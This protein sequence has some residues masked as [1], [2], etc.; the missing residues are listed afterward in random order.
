MTKQ[1]MD[2]AARKIH[3]QCAIVECKNLMGKVMYYGVAW[4]N[5]KM[6]EL[7]SERDDCLLEMPWGIYDGRKGVER[8]Y[9]QDFG[10]RNDP[11]KLEKLKGVMMLYT[12]DTPIIEVAEDGQSAKGVWISSG[13]DTW[14]EGDAHPQGYWRWGK[15]AVEFLLEQGKWKIWRM[16]FYPFFLTK[17]DESWTKAPAYDWSFFPVTPDRPR[18]T[19][20]YHYDGVSVYPTGQPPIPTPY[21]HMER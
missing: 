19:P 6:V 9:L 5:R 15:Y 4:L 16:R 7:W 17:Y 8:C 12:V 1:T 11:G 13:A 21:E 14:R 10:D 2:E 3:R 18:E 20:V